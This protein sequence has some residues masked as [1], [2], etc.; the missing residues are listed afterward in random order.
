MDLE[1]MRVSE[2]FLKFDG[3]GDVRLTFVRTLSKAK[4]GN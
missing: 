2:F 4:E 3:F 1:R